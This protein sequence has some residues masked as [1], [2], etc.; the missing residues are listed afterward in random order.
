MLATVQ[1]RIFNVRR[2]TLFKIVSDFGARR[3][4][5]SRQGWKKS[6]HFTQATPSAFER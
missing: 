3:V 6:Y 4:P 2:T 1:P 5:C